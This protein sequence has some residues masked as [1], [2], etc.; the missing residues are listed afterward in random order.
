MA[1]P[2]RAEGAE[3]GVAGG[4]VVIATPSAFVSLLLSS[5]GSSAVRV[6]GGAALAS[7]GGVES[8]CVLWAGFV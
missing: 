5:A 1:V 3:M 6:V 4:G 8:V 7:V 2:D